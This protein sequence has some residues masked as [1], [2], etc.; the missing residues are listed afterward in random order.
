M[1]N[2]SEGEGPTGSDKRSA[3]TGNANERWQR[4]TTRSKGV[5][6]TCAIAKR[7]LHTLARFELSRRRQ[8]V[9]DLSHVVAGNERFRERSKI[10]LKA[11]NQA[12]DTVTN[13]DAPARRAEMRVGK[14]TPMLERQEMAVMMMMMNAYG[15]MGIVK[16]RSCFKLFSH[17]L[18]LRVDSAFRDLIG[19]GEIRPRPFFYGI[20][21]NFL[22]NS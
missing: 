11:G 8:K 7:S 16:T 14:A 18:W 9:Q 17:T 6:I 10:T 4:Q 2:A 19:R 13:T 12:L 3:S 15:I 21:E 22:E 5:M 1:T 20:H